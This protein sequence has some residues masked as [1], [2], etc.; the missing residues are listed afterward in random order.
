MNAAEVQTMLKKALA[1]RDKA[2]VGLFGGLIY[3]IGFLH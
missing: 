1:K 3:C 2:I